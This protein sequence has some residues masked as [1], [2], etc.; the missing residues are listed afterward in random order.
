MKEIETQAWKQQT[1]SDQMGRGWGIT[2]ER[3]K[4][5]D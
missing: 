3:K 2:V 4:G 5:K 1:D